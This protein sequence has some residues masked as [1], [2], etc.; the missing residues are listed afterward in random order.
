M[1]QPTT[2]SRHV[3]CRPAEKI[4][5]LTTRKSHAHSRTNLKSVP[6]GQRHAVYELRDRAWCHPNRDLW[7]TKTWLNIDLSSQRTIQASTDGTWFPPQ[8]DRTS[9][10]PARVLL[11]KQTVWKTSNASKPVRML[12]SKLL[13]TC[14]TP[15]RNP[16]DR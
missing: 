4:G 3:H 10:L 15:D 16:A 14:S 6:F 8:M 13:A 9:R 7:R 1:T 2:T 12:M 11:Q 5:E